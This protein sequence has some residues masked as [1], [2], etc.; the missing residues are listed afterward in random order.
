MRNELKKL[1]MV[2]CLALLLV[3]TAVYSFSVHAEVLAADPT[4]VPS[5]LK[6]I[7]DWVV[8]IPA[9]GPVIL[10]VLKW[11]GVV[12]AVLTGV[13]TLVT[14]VA[15]SLEV[16]GQALG[17]QEFAKKVKAFYDAVWPYIAWLSMYN[18]QKKTL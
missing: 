12:A 15:K 9:V 5:W 17:F 18:V 16:L 7:I 11:A 3:L 6:L 8:A 13:A 1:L 2:E 14:G 4:E 10:S